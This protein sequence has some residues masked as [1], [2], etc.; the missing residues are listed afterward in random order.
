MGKIKNLSRKGLPE[1]S[2]EALLEK[3]RNCLLELQTEEY[4]A[5]REKRKT[6]LC[7]IVY[8]AGKCAG[9]L[10]WRFG[11]LL[12]AFASTCIFGDGPAEYQDPLGSYVVAL[13]AYIFGATAVHFKKLP[14]S[15]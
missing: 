14:D 8:V 11:W 7:G 10:C 2:P 15:T 1:L 5:K 12:I 9:F 6:K 3:K 13:A 4:L